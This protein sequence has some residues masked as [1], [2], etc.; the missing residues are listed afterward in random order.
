V[1]PLLVISARDN[2][3]TALEALEPGRVVTIGAASLTIAEHIPRGHKVSLTDIL[4][5]GALV[6]Y[7]SAIGVASV[8]IPAGAHVHVHNVASARGRGD[9]VRPT[10]AGGARIAEPPDVPEAAEGE[11]AVAP[12][13]GEPNAV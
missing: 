4:P 2:V 13:L 6:K 9:L 11:L 7:G 3:A 8:R 10:P 1:N 12:S 5:G